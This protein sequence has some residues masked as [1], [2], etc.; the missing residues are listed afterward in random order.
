M[1]RWPQCP[2][3]YHRDSA[4]TAEALIERRDVLHSV[5]LRGGNDRRVRNAHSSGAVRAKFTQR[6]TGEI[7]TGQKIQFVR[8]EQYLRHVHGSATSKPC[9]PYC[10]NF[11]KHVLD[12][13]EASEIASKQGF[14]DGCGHRVMHIAPVMERDEEA[15]V[16]E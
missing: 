1:P 10:H 6:G 4:D 12:W 7:A 16:E 14:Q 9:E 13:Q 15:R 2:S 5:A 11:E 3:R 8:A